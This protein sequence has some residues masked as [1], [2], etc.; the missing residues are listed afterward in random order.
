MDEKP[1]DIY[2]IKIV[3]IYVAANLDSDIVLCRYFMVASN[4]FIN[5]IKIC[6]GGSVHT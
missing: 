5:W 4:C 6:R 1:P 3:Y 2:T